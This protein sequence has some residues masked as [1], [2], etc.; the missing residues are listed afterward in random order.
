[1]L[2]PS[3]KGGDLAVLNIH[4]ARRH[5]QIS[6]DGFVTSVVAE[7]RPN[8]Q[9]W[10]TFILAPRKN[11]LNETLRTQALCIKAIEEAEARERKN[12]GKRKN[13][14]HCRIDRRHSVATDSL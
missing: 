10:V 7:T 1:L 13:W 4:L 11:T 14:L 5:Y 6:L 2:A 8:V 9:Y 12:G 3:A